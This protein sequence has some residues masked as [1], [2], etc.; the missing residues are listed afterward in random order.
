MSDND[1][2]KNTA[3]EARDGLDGARHLSDD[4][5]DTA[6]DAIDSAEAAATGIAA[7]VEDLGHKAKQAAH[8]AMTTTSRVAAEAVDTTQK[9][10]REKPGIAWGAVAA[11]ALG[12]IA[13]IT[14]TAR[15]R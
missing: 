6:R 2:I 5:K 10:F 9:T 13:A 12:I 3:D 15:H 4:T 7:E 14:I 8:E 11:L 1:T